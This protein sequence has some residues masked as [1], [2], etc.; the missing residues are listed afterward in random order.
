MSSAKEKWD[1]SGASE[2]ISKFSATI[3]DSTKNYISLLPDLTSRTYTNNY[4]PTGCY[5]Y[6]SGSYHDLRYNT[7]GKTTSTSRY[8]LS[9]CLNTV[10]EPTQCPGDADGNNKVD[11]E[12]LLVLL[13]TYGKTGSGL[14][15]D[16]KADKKIDVEDLLII[17]SNYG[18][19]CGVRKPAA[20]NTKY[21]KIT[22]DGPVG[23]N[24]KGNSWDL[25][26]VECWDLTRSN[27][28][29][30]M[31]PSAASH[32]NYNNK[33]PTKNLVDGNKNT[34]WAG[35]PGKCSFYE[36]GGCQHVTLEFDQPTKNFKCTLSQDKKDA[37]WAVEKI[38]IAQS[39]GS[40]F[41]L[42]IKWNIGKGDTPDIKACTAKTCKY[43]SPPPPPPSPPSSCKSLVCP[44][45]TTVSAG[46]PSGWT[47]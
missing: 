45:V 32:D 38:T 18:K 47:T 43:K 5:L 44:V 4:Q 21:L 42:P 37:R 41:T 2:A 10:K 16:F 35:H 7:K 33:Y 30:K 8:Y 28:K 39:A 29:I 14:K 24:K 1:S 23:Q 27:R 36:H 12:D 20:V 46:A 34:F 11:V 19:S 22:Q 13:G 15:A 17:L 26:E 40:K 3:P 31:K 6:K 9:I 25:M